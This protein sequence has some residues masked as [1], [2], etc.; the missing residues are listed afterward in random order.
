MARSGLVSLRSSLPLLVPALALSVLLGVFQVALAP[1]WAGHPSGPQLATPT[2]KPP[3]S[4][5]W[6]G[7]AVTLFLML[8][9]V[10]PF[11]PYA[12]A[13][14]AAAQL[15]R[16]PGRLL[17]ALTALPVGAAALI[18]PGSS[19]DIFDYVGFERMW[20]VYGDNPLFALPANHPT[21]WATPF[22]WFADRTP[23]Y[24]PLWALLTW[25]IA[26]LAGESASAVVEGYKVL[27]IAAYALCAWLVWSSSDPDRRGRALV[28]FA[29]SPL[30]LVEVAGK[31][32][33]DIFPA[34]GVVL[35]VWLAGRWRNWTLLLSLPAI[36]GGALVKVIAL[37]IAPVLLVQFW[38]QRRRRA[39]AAALGLAAGLAILCYAPFWQGPLTL[40]PI[41]NQTS[42]VIWSPTS[43][44]LILSSALSG[45]AHPVA[46]RALAGA[47]WAVAGAIIVCRARPDTS[48]ALASAGG[49]LLLATVLLLTSAMY[50]H[51]LLPVIALAAVSGDARLQRVVL[52]LSIGGMAAYNVDW[53]STTLGVQWLASD[54]YRVLGTLIML[55]PALLV[56]LWAWLQTA[57]AATPMALAPG[58]T[59]RP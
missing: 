30:V 40:A 54:S 48:A 42:R 33:N 46:V 45:D 17:F 47:L 27:S 56:E 16:L 55:G 11:Q 59:T 18:Y 10:L 25:P 21:D 52:W 36:V 28:A 13:Q 24:G 39:A 20:T 41:W 31:V 58:S 38:R 49:W 34:L 2:P 43:L 32:H 7:A 15:E 53:L 8:G 5:G 4:I 3:A 19:S 44:L 12:L 22:V 26:Q 1:V 51:Y 14:R 6:A 23:A 35:A 9:A 50:A 37:P 29:W 57:G